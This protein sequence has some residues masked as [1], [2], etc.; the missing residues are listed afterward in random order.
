MAFTRLS[1]HETRPGAGGVMPGR[2]FVSVGTKLILHTF[3][4][5]V[6]TSVILY[7]N[8]TSRERRNALAGK[9]TEATMVV[10]LFSQFV[11][12][13]IDFDDL[14]GLRSDV[15]N[16][17]E[18]PDIDEVAVYSRE[19]ALLGAWTRD[20]RPP[21]E[22]PARDRLG[23]VDVDDSHMTLYLAIIGA[24]GKEV[25]AATF[26]FSLARENAQQ[27][28]SRVQNPPPDFGLGRRDGAGAHVLREGTDHRAPSHACPGRRP[29]RTRRDR[30]ARRGRP[31]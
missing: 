6:V 21:P 5:L 13:R 24:E 30:R 3:G 7:V 2:R 22:R 28:D 19:G 9:R 12:P 31:Q 23:T 18:N 27:R 4:V 1:T 25:G 8:L 14:E 11:S 20:G 16:L 10:S 29:P 17:S 26:L 15:R